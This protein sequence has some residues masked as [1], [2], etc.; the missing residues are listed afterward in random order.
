MLPKRTQLWEGKVNEETSL[1]EH[2]NE[3]IEVSTL[4]TSD[5]MRN[6]ILYMISLY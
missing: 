5:D 4:N 2:P 1:Y 3:S 6:H